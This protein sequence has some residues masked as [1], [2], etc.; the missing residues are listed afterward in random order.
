[1]QISDK[2]CF[3]IYTMALLN[4]PGYKILNEEE[5]LRSIQ[6]WVDKTEK[7]TL[8]KHR[9]SFINLQFIYNMIYQNKFK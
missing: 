7:E 3:E 6:D 2:G 9:K 4:K 8:K 5:C 1:M